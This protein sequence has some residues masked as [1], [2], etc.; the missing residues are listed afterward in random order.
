MAVFLSGMG[1][2]TLIIFGCGHICTALAPMAVECGFSVTA[3]D[4]RADFARKDSS[5]FR[6]MS[7]KTTRSP[8][9]SDCSS[10]FSDSLVLVTHKHK[11][12]G[13]I[14]DTLLANPN[15]SRDISG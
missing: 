10:V 5:R 15:P 8:M 4:D 9:R 6:R 11:F 3:V 1:E 14:L 13:D 12:D 7:F 2:R